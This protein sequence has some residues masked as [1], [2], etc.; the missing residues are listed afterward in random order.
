[1]NYG[2]DATYTLTDLKTNQI[3]LR[4]RAFSRVTYDIPGQEQ[5]FAG[6]RAQRDAAGPRV[7]GA[8]RADQAAPG[9]VFPR[10]DL[11]LIRLRRNRDS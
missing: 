1:M 4:G 11:I 3:V 10:G 9:V 7:E 2:I 5:R 6:L 8:V